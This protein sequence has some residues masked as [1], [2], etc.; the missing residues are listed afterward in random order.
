VIEAGYEVFGSE[1]DNVVNRKLVVAEI[2]GGVR[3]LLK[4]V[5]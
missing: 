1:S 5:P 3:P 2:S 4:F